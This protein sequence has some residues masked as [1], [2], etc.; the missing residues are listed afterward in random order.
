LG[1]GSRR[2]RKGRPC[3][4]VAIARALEPLE[5]EEAKKRQSTLNNPDLASGNLPEAEKGRARDKL[6]A[7][8]GLFERTLQKAMRIVEAA[9]QEPE[10]Y[11]PLVEE[12]DRTGKVDGVYK[13]FARQQQRI[14]HNGFNPPSENGG[15]L[16]GIE[17]WQGRD[18]QRSTIP[19]SLRASCPKRRK[20]EPLTGSPS[21]SVQGDGHY[22]RP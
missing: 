12:M 19:A 3:E 5:R 20:G 18:N 8:V 14:R 21:R 22:R 7:A 17:L 13:E 6:A 16:T 10:R 4:A 9:E 1:G 11:G 2:A 15:L